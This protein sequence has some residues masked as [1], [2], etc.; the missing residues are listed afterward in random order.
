MKTKKFKKIYVEI[1]NACNLKCPFCLPLKREKKYMN[2]ED[3]QK[4]IFQ[5]KDYTNYIYLHILGEPL[6]HPNLYE[7]LNICKDNKVFVNMTTNGTLIKD[8]KDIL[9]NSKAL[10]QLN[11]SLHSW[12]QFDEKSQIRYLDELISLIK[13]LEKE[14]YFYLSLR[15]WL[16]N[17]QLQN[18]ALSYLEDKLNIKISSDTKEISRNVFLSFSDQFTWPSE[19]KEPSEFVMCHGI[20]DHIG[21]LVDGTVVPCCLDGNGEINLGNIFNNN[22]DEIL[23]S[24]RYLKMLKAFE[25]RQMQEK[26]CL[27]CSFKNRFI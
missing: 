24:D 12:G 8:K 6:L 23:N 2:T 22:L 21:I 7:I 19:E 1:T 13:T 17:N 3:F 11:V 20:K 25:T 5:I 27:N 14:D 26:L 18:M 9:L 16:G 15:F 10:R 4:V